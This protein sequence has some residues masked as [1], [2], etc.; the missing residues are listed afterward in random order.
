MT[1]ETPFNLVY[2]AGPERRRTD[3]RMRCTPT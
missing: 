2:E 3:R 1:T